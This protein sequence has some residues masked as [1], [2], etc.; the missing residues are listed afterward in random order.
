[1]LQLLIFTSKYLLEEVLSIQRGQCLKQTTNI[2]RE[3]SN[4]EV[5]AHIIQLILACPANVNIAMILVRNRAQAVWA[6]SKQLIQK[7]EKR[8]R[9]WA[10]MSQLTGGIRV[11]TLGLNAMLLCGDALRG[12]TLVFLIH[13]TN[14]YVLSSQVYIV[15]NIENLAYKFQNP[16]LLS[17]N[18]IQFH[19]DVLVDLPLLS[20]SEDFE[21]I[22]QR[23]GLLLL[24]VHKFI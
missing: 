3:N 19:V 9:Q 10:D 17:K 16:L 12:D 22:S 18:G 7:G 11:L 24:L 1:M 4:M 21:P 6:Y 8:K 15:E 23:P 20:F 2:D 5:D 13:S 14:T